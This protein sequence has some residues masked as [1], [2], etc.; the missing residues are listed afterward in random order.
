MARDRNTDR[1]GMRFEQS[2]VDEVW[3]KGRTIRNYDPEI[4]RFDVCGSV[5]KRSEYGN[6]D[7]D[8]G[9]EID[10]IRPVA[11]GGTD[12]LR[13]LQPLYWK[14]NREKADQ[15]PWSCP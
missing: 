4:W 6:T 7:S 14:T 10:H 5:M 15:Y 1:F 9:W 8:H 3:E 13:N 12:D 2:K 11:K